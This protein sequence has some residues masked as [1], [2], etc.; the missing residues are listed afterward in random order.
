MD[1]WRR[2]IRNIF[3]GLLSSS[4]TGESINRRGRVDDFIL[5]I[6]YQL[7]HLMAI[8]T[9]SI[10]ITR[11][12]LSTLLLPSYPIL[13]F[14]FLSSPRLSLSFFL[15]SLLVVRL[16]RSDLIGIG[17]GLALGLLWIGLAFLEDGKSRFR[18]TI[19]KALY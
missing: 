17:Y 11:V 2:C 7:A 10:S 1:E 14:P 19:R 12:W 5:K 18:R 15:S 3:D 9:S 6:S 16:V 8:T 4:T 13:P